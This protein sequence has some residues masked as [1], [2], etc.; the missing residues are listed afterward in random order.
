MV[1]LQIRIRLKDYFFEERTVTNTTREYS[2]TYDI[3]ISYE[4]YIAPLLSSP[5][6]NISPKVI[7]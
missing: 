7:S 2:S 4:I 3:Y 5:V 6:L 1:L